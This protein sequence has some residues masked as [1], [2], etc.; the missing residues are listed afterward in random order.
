MTLP[1]LELAI[2][3]YLFGKINREFTIFSPTKLMIAGNIISVLLCQ[4]RS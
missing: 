1:G 2:K 4:G 3:N